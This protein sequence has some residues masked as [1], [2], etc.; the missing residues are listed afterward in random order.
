MSIK[1]EYVGE[2]V[3]FHHSID[4][5]P[6]SDNFAMHTHEMC[7][8]YYFISGKGSYHVE[9][10]FYPLEPGCLM[11]MRPAEAH[12]L[13]V[14]PELP[15][16]RMALNIFPDAIR[17]IDPNGLLFEAFYERDS[18]QLNMYTPDEFQDANYKRYLVSMCRGG[19]NDTERRLQ[20]MANVPPLLCEIR[21]VFLRKKPD[22]WSPAVNDTVRHLVQFI[23]GNLYSDLSLEQISTQFFFSKAHL[24][25]MFRQAMGQSI[26]RYVIIKRLMDARQ[27]IRNGEP[28]TSVSQRYSNWDYSAFYRSYKQHFAVSPKDDS[29]RFQNIKNPSSRA[30]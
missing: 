21:T 5:V 10:S 4:Q 8:I 9:G 15:Y 12:H 25:R 14:T 18:G 11:L 7:E 13:Q 16:E 3:Y 19:K 22:A 29:N 26:W 28:V 23:N 2:D 1:Y 24:N 27:H 30:L 20:I 6:C 17:D